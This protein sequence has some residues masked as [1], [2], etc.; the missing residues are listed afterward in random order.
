M[1]KSDVM[2]E[3][4]RAPGR[5]K[6]D[7]SR[8]AGERHKEQLGRLLDAAGHVFAE[9]GWADATVEAI[10]NRAGMSRRTFYEHFDDLKDCL[11]TFHQKATRR[12]FRAVEMAVTNADT[13]RPG[14]M[15]NLGVQGF[16]GGI[17]MFPHVAR[18]IF[19]VVRAAGPEFEAAHE[20]MIGRFVRL[21]QDGVARAHKL[22]RTA[23]PPD[24]LRTFALVSGMEAVAMRYVMRGEEEKAMEAA[25]ILIDMVQR[26]FGGTPAPT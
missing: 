7:R 24:E 16:L 3:S 15:L 18:V 10:V 13:S 26:T 5:G 4:E 17:A 8:S 19:R 21:V 9:T 6:Y 14:E 2:P 23:I 11:L 25:P 12:A 1:A 22:G 20:Q